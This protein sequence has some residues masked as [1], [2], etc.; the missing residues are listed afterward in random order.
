MQPGS[1]I[2]GAGVAKEKLYS[3]A[4]CTVDVTQTAWKMDTYIIPSVENECVSANLGRGPIHYK[5]ACNADGSVHSQMYLDALCTRPDNRTLTGFERC[6]LF[7]VE[8]SH[9]AKLCGF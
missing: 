9:M 2:H 8:T 1:D 6:I 7:V 3:D 5:A 4:K